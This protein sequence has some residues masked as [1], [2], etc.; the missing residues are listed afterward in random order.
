ML[1]KYAVVFRKDLKMETAT[2]TERQNALAFATKETLAGTVGVELF[3]RE[4][5]IQLRAEVVPVT[6][7]SAAN[8]NGKK[9]Q[10]KAAKATVKPKRAAA[11][12]KPKAKAKAAKK[13]GFPKQCI[14]PSCRKK[15]RGPRFKF[16]CPDHIGASAKTI[17]KWKD[18]KE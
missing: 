6:E 10:R 18:G 9:P 7:E 2:F 3:K 15:N 4:G 16:L 11:K 1:E 13:T 8:G 17:A 12:A 14:N 5:A